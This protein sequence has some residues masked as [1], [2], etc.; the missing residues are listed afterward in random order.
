MLLPAGGTW[1]TGQHVCQR[2]CW[3]HREREHGRT[4]HPRSDR[5]DRWPAPGAGFERGSRAAMASARRAGVFP[6]GR[7]HCALASS[8]TWPLLCLWVGRASHVAGVQKLFPPRRWEPAPVRSRLAGR[9][10]PCSCLRSPEKA[11]GRDTHPLPQGAGP[12]MPAPSSVLPLGRVPASATEDPE[13]LACAWL[14]AEGVGGTADTA[15]LP[16][17]PASASRAGGPPRAGGAGGLERG[18][19]PQTTDP[20]P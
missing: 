2:P 11:P 13:P 8:V 20:R 12:P 14:T 10:A 19:C 9:K 17:G 15:H 4:G 7:G 16:R 1:G 6:G 18:L 5:S 3:P